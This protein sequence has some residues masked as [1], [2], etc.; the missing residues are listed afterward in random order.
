MAG[1]AVDRAEG[2]AV[3]DVTQ[4]FLDFIRRHRRRR[5]RPFSILA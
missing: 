3:T 5:S 4:T 1:I 2:S